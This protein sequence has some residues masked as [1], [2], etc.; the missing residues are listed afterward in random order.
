VGWQDDFHRA[1]AANLGPNWTLHTPST[2][3]G[4]FIISSDR[5]GLVFSSLLTFAVYNA[6]VAPDDQWS[7]MTFDPYLPTSTNN[8]WGP[9]VRYNLSSNAKYFLRCSQTEIILRAATGDNSGS[10]I[11]NVANVVASGDRVKLCAVGDQIWVEKNDTIV[12]GPFTNSAS[13]SGQPGM[14]GS[15][16]AGTTFCT[17][18]KGGP[19]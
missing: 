13:T 6:V 3:N 4:N 2:G 12:L 17:L 8:G 18:W 11:G 16:A 14:Q 10:T 9:V 5:A 7:E 1:D 19:L 15:Q